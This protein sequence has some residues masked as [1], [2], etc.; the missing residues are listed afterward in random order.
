M[1]VFKEKWQ[2]ETLVNGLVV[3]IGRKDPESVL[4]YRNFDMTLLNMYITLSDEL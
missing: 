2:E 1:H 3:F 4:Q